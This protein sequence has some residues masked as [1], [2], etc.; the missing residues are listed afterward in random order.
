LNESGLISQTG[1]VPGNAESLEFEVYNNID[2]ALY[3]TLGGQNLSFSALSED[4]DYT[5]YGANIPADMDGQTEA[6][7]FGVQGPTPGVLLDNIEFSSLS[8]PEPSECALAGLGA[9]LLSIHHWRK[10]RNCV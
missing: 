5:V 4:P 10:L 9:I 1:L 8:V 7:I 3:V 2:N 6:L